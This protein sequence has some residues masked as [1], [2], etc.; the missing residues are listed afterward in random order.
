[1]E[2][3]KSGTNVAIL[4]GKISWILVDQDPGKSLDLDLRVGLL[5][6]G[7]IPLTA[8][9]P[10]CQ[11]L[12]HKRVKIGRITHLLVLNQVELIF[13]GNSHVFYCTHARNKLE[14]NLKTASFRT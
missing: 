5:R 9:L 13:L 8:S 3:K 11:I 2:R 6:L 12:L 10:I 7:L 1:M 14:I 4:P